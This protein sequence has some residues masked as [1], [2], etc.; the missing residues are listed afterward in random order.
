MKNIDMSEDRFYWN[1]IF[2]KSYKNRHQVELNDGKDSTVLDGDIIRKDGKL[3]CSI[4]GES[5]HH[6]AK[7]FGNMD[8]GVNLVYVCPNCGGR[9]RAIVESKQECDACDEVL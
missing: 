7:M 1:C 4:C 6:K 3:Y 9:F 8:V 2:P 5:A